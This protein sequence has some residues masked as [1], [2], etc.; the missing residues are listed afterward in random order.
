VRSVEFHPE[1]QD[2][3]LAAARFY[4]DQTDG[5]WL[6]FMSASTSWRS[7]TFTGGQVT[8]DHGCK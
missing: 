2:E 5:L 4:E 6:D 1:A 3:F 7:C 8:G